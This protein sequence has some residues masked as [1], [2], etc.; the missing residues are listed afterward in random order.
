V[1][2]YKENNCGNYYV[3]VSSDFLSN[4]SLENA[5]IRLRVTLSTN[6]TKFSPEIEFVRFTI[7]NA[8]AQ[9]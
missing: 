2:L 7:Y 5:R 6:N 1:A 8:L 9:P 3:G 4:I